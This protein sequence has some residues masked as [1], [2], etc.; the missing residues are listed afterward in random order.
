[1]DENKDYIARVSKD[2]YYER[3]RDLYLGTNSIYNTLNRMFCK[4][5]NNYFGR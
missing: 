2:L 3:D 5:Y 1:M 4:D